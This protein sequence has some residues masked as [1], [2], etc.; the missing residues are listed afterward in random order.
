MAEKGAMLTLEY[1]ERALERL[2]AHAKLVLVFSD[3][4]PWL[5]L[6]VVRARASSLCPS[7]SLSVPLSRPLLVISMSL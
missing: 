1:Y 2:H 5:P 3:D 4:I 6:A 7:L